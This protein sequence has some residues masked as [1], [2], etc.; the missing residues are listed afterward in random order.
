[1]TTLVSIPHERP[2]TPAVVEPLLRGRFGVPYLWHAEC[3]STQDVLRDTAL[4]EGAVAATDHQ[5]AGRGREARRWVDEAGTALLFSLL[6][7]PPPAAPVA[8]LS[9]VCALAVAET[10]DEAAGRAAAIK[11]PNDVLVDGGKVAGILLEAREGDVLCGIGLNVNQAEAALP[12][13]TRAPAGS[14][15]TAT[16]RKHDRAGLLVELLERLEARYDAW[17]ASGLTALLPELERRDALRGRAVAVGG[18]SGVATGMA[19][20]GRLRVAR[21]DGTVLLVASGE[22]VEVPG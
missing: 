18:V 19:A 9:L 13:G 2:P 4:P 3:G 7:R 22:V 15:R 10:V 17:L 1:V 8:Q 11:W 12:T 5:T 16:G 14:L 21:A 6:L 20:D